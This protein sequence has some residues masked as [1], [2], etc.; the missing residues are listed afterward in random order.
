MPRLRDDQQLRL[1]EIQPLVAENR[2]SGGV[3]GSPDT[4]RNHRDP[5]ELE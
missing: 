1:I 3:E 2:R 4:G 5:I